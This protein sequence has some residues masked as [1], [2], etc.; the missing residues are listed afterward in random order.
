MRDTQS[1]GLVNLLSLSIHDCASPSLG[2]RS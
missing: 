1:Y 2:E